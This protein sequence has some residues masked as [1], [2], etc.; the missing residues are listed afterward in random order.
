MTDG[1]PA[2]SST[3]SNIDLHDDVQAECYYDNRY[4]GG[5]M[6]EWPPEKLDRVGKVVLALG[7]P[8]TGA[9]L[10]YG[11]GTGVFSE[12]LG[13]ILPGWQIAGTELSGQA[14]EIARQRCPTIRFFN[15]QDREARRGTFDLVFTHHVIEHVSDL[16]GTANDILSLLKPG[17][18]ML[19]IL[20]CGN[21]G[22]LERT[23]CEWHT[24]GINPAV[25]NRFFFEDEGHLRRLTSD[26]FEALWNARGCRVTS[27]Q[28][29]N[30]RAGAIKYY[31]ESTRARATSIAQPSDGKTPLTTMALVV[32][33]GALQA[34]WAARRP[35]SALR[36]K[37]RRG[38]RSIRDVAIVSICAACW[39]VSFVVNRAIQRLADR[40]WSR[41]R[42]A[43]NGTEMYVAVQGP[44]RAQV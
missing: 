3:S 22:S 31:T 17:G 33:Q 29:A 16:D 43:P 36:E 4:D 23:L 38:I 26:E 14:L 24:H 8:A 1:T 27:K 5:Y 21:N 37:R 35:V 28:F 18:T 32:V 39:P 42:L 10:D 7:L 12:M 2:L 44:D 30:Q 40:E 11:C 19:H 20:P 9:A 13:N 25:G 34:L 15:A 6:S 41:R